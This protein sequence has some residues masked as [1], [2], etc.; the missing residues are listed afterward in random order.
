MELMF[1]CMV[2]VGA[3]VRWQ[4][5]VQN[6]SRREIVFLVSATIEHHIVI[7]LITDGLLLEHNDSIKSSLYALVV[8]CKLHICGTS[9]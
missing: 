3:N 1:R 6:A 9:T 8:A 7:I 4:H 2:G 5:M